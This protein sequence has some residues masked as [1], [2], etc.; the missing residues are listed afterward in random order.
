MVGAR[1]GQ[2][3]DRRGAGLPV[4]H[5]Q[6]RHDE[7]GHHLHGPGLPAQQ[8]LLRGGDLGEVSS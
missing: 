3:S 1:P 5:A 2:L 7:P 4:R 6:L 8:L